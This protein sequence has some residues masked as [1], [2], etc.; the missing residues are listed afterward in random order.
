MH[1]PVPWSDP[2]LGTE[3]RVYIRLLVL[4]A[5]PVSRGLC[6]SIAPP[7]EGYMPGECLKSVV[8]ALAHWAPR[9]S[10]EQPG[11]RKSVV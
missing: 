6:V 3:L 1:T 2:P 7:K 10:G 5:G 9:P 4:E 11:D 8:L